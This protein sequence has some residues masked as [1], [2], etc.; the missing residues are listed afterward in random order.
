M[1]APKIR[2]VTVGSRAR[3]RFV[4]DIGSDPVTGKRKQL[5]R[6]YDRKKD[7]ERELARILSEV[8]RG[9]FAVP[10]R[11]TVGEY[12][13]DWLRSATREKEAATARNYADAL[14][15]VRD[16]LGTV[17]LQKLTT[18]QIEDLI[19]WMATEGRRRGGK[20]GTPLG[21]R[22]IQLTLSRLRSALRDAVRHRLVDFNV[23]EPVRPPRQTGHRRTPWAAEEVRTFLRA[24]DGKR[25]AAPLLLSLLGLRP[26]EVCGMRWSDVDLVGETITVANTRTLVATDAG[27]V[28]VEKG[29]KSAAGRRELPLPAQV[30]TALHRLYKVQAAER[31]AAGPAYT[32]TGYVLV[33]E[34]GQPCRTDWLRRQAY[35]AMTAAG[36]RKVRLYDARHAALTYL[37]VNGVPPVIVSAWAGHSDLSLA[38]RVYVHPTAKDL[39]QGRDA[40]SAL[41]G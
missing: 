17:P 39:E 29:P 26:A 35:G 23:A 32:P 37:A 30:T 5:T 8:D 14:R 19:D 13:S 4:V 11:L 3:Y 28:V 27:M 10:S 31:L 7:A 40:L 9:A 38:A 2:P 41:L 24:L 6:T 12:L 1:A 34:L 15:P 25:L 20:P 22:T 16:R 18:R 21:P 36:V 33:D